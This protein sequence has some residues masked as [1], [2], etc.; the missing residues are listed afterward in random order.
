MGRRRASIILPVVLAVFVAL[1]AACGT[2]QRLHRGSTIAVWDLDDLSPSE[3]ERPFLGELLS[4]RVIETIKNG[5]EYTVIERE[6]LV[7]ALEELRLGSTELTE[8]ATRL[9]LGRISGA[10]FMIFGAYQIVGEQMRLDLRL[11]EVETAKV[12]NAVQK[13]A[14]ASDVSGWL[15]IT[16]KAATELVSIP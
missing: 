13:T 10:R 3:I 12:W 5:R 7:L 16:A 9:R 6:R 4:G 1:S 2:K 15:D 8:D 14:H 11:V